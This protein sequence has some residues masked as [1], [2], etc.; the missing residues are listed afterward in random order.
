[1]ESASVFQSRCPR[2][3]TLIIVMLIN[4]VVLIMTYWLFSELSSNATVEVRGWTA[5]GALAGFIILTFLE[6]K[7]IDHFSPPTIESRAAYRVVRSFYE[8]IQHRNFNSA[9]NLI[10]ND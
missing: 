4:L 5:G 10:H 6:L 3:N 9:W 8:E 7:L 2:L 1:M